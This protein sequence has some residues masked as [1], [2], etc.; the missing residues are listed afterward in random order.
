MSIMHHY[1]A[2]GGTNVCKGSLLSLGSH[3][4]PVG[5]LLYQHGDPLLPA[6]KPFAARWEPFSD[7]IE[8]P[9]RPEGS[10]HLPIEVFCWQKGF[11][12]CR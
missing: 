8:I 11:L 1:P 7:F 10:L 6:R 2:S 12:F 5:A 4:L 3:L 9:L